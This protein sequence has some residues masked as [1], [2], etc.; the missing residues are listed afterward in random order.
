M[1]SYLGGLIEEINAVKKNNI[2]GDKILII[3]S[4]LH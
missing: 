2:E 4:N 1:K 3:M